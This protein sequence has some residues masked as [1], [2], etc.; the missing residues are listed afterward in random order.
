MTIGLMVYKP[1]LQ[2]EYELCRTEEK[3][4]R[5]CLKEGK[6]VTACG[7]KFA[8]EVKKTCRDEAEAFARCMDWNSFDLNFDFCRR[9]EKIFDSCMKHK[10]GKEKP[11]FGYFTQVRIHQSERARPLPAVP[12]WPDKTRGIPEDHPALKELPR[13][14]SRY[15]WYP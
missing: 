13:H 15:Y 12:E 6:K 5:N 1:F 14:G 7:L 3:D 9:E 11:P 10:M 8:Q 4:P 2:Q